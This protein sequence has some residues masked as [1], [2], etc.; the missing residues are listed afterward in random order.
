[1]SFLDELLSSDDN[2]DDDEDTES[3]LSVVTYNS[4]VALLGSTSIF[5]RFLLRTCLTGVVFPA[6]SDVVV[7]LRPTRGE[8]DSRLPTHGDRDCD[9]R[10]ST[11]IFVAVSHVGE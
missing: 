3:A 6:S 4:G 7:A 5:T 2:D 11:S 1:M 8:S 9:A 10:R